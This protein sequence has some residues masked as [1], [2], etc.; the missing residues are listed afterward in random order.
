MIRPHRAFSIISRGVLTA[1]A[2]AI[3]CSTGQE[4][5]SSPS[6][7][8]HLIDGRQVDM[9][10]SVAKLEMVA[11]YIRRFDLVLR[12]RRATYRVNDRQP[13]FLS[14]YQAGDLTLVRLK[15]GDDHDDRNL[16]VMVNR[17]GTGLEIPVEETVELVVDSEPGG[18]LRLTPRLSLEPGE[19]GFVSPSDLNR[20][21]AKMFDFGVD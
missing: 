2:M 10:P 6:P 7:L 17:Q 21:P 8:Y 19:Y 1:A 12:S 20:L 11:P 14:G 13:T 18:L 16:K 9:A 3:G 15:S 4:V 5:R